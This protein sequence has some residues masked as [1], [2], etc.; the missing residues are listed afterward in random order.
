MSRPRRLTPAQVRA[1]EELAR[2]EGRSVWPSNTTG[3]GCV[4]RGTADALEALGLVDTAEH[5]RVSPVRVYRIN[6]AGLE[7]LEVERGYDE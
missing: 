1:L 7:A 6:A 4:H 2:L 3:N 5:G